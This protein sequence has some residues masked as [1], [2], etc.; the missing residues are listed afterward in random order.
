MSNYLKMIRQMHDIYIKQRKEFDDANGIISPIR[1]I[2]FKL[3]YDLAK[4]LMEYSTLTEEGQNELFKAHS[5]QIGYFVACK[6]LATGD[7]KT[8]WSLCAMEDLFANSFDKEYG[9][10]LAISRLFDKNDKY[11][12]QSIWKQSKSGRECVRC[13]Q[14]RPI[15]F[16]GEGNT[17]T[18]QADAFLKRCTRYYK[19]GT[20]K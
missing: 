7:I 15:L 11:S 12:I 5:M 13:F 10:T 18:S 2:L 1:A 8:A 3:N 4:F 16:F 14:N 17:I 20:V 9:L 6:E 19:V